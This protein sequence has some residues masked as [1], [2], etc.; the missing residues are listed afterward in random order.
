V[1]PGKSGSVGVTEES[2][3]CQ[4]KSDSN[5]PIVPTFNQTEVLTSLSQIDHFAIGPTMIAAPSL[6]TPRKF[7]PP[8]IYI[9]AAD[10]VTIG[11]TRSGS[12]IS[13]GTKSAIP[14]RRPS[15]LTGCSK[16]ASSASA[17]A[18]TSR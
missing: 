10:G 6:L 7:P 12:P 2:E 5:S 1:I 13:P 11:L 14:D 18:G 16:G 17:P 8:D 3:H 15:F 9:T 4:H